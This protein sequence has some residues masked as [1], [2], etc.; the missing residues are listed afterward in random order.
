MGSVIV[1]AIL[2]VPSVFNLLKWKTQQSNLLCSLRLFPLFQGYA[3]YLQKSDTAYGAMIWLFTS[4]I[5]VH[6]SE[7]SASTNRKVWIVELVIKK[8]IRVSFSQGYS[9]FYL[10]LYFMKPQLYSYHNLLQ[11][12]AGKDINQEWNR[13]ANS[14]TNW[15]PSDSLPSGGPADLHIYWRPTCLQ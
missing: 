5:Y 4:F 11:Y 10:L 13:R 12:M 14:V 3:F 9:P 7:L 6:I 15:S 8:N 2:A 1:I